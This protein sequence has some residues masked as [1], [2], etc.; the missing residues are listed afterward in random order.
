MWVILVLG[1]SGQDSV[2]KVGTVPAVL[3][4]KLPSGSSESKGLSVGYAQEPDI[5][6]VLSLIQSVPGSTPGTGTIKAVKGPVSRD[7]NGDGSGPI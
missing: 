4:R 2:Q 5:S 7:F 6:Q 3:G 1:G